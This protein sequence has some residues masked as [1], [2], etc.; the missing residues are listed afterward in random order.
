MFLDAFASCPSHDECHHVKSTAKLAKEISS[1]TTNLTRNEI[2]DAIS[3]M[4]QY[5]Y[6]VVTFGEFIRDLNVSIEAIGQFKDCFPPSNYS[7]FN[8]KYS[9]IIAGFFK[10]KEHLITKNFD[11][12]SPYDDEVTDTFPVMILQQ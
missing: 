2:F 3:H 8:S 5:H 11:P 9:E 7:E 1:R 10:L 6:P 12:L 4:T